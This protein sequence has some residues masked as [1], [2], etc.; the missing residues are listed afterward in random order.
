LSSEFLSTSTL[1]IF[2]RTTCQASAA[3]AVEWEGLSALSS[4][5][6]SVPVI[7]AS[8]E[9]SSAISDWLQNRNLPNVVALDYPDSRLGVFLHPQAYLIGTDGTLLLRLAPYRDYVEEELLSVQHV[10]SDMAAIS[11]DVPSEE[12]AS[13]A[14]A[15]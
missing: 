12:Q 6:V 1:I 13:S 11:E 7:W 14:E 5:T 8:S 15:K 3:V 9:S 10:G 4:G 2:F